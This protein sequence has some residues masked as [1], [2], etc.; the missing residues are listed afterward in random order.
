MTMLRDVAYWRRRLGFLPV[1]LFGDTD[2]CRFVLLNGSKGNFCLDVGHRSEDH[3]QR[4]I[5][6]SADVDH[7]ISVA[8]DVSVYRWDQRSVETY[9]IQE[10]EPNLDKFQGY[11]E[12]RSAPRE[13]SIVS[14]AI[15][16]YRTLRARVESGSDGYTALLAYLALLSTAAARQRSSIEIASEWTDSHVAEQAVL[17]SLRASDSEQL[18]DLLLSESIDGNVPNIELMIRH[19]AGRI[20]QEAHYLAFVDPQLDLFSAGQ[21]TPTG[22]SGAL[23]AFF[24]PTPLVRTV[25]EQAFAALPVAKLREIRIFD[26][27][28]GSGE[29]LR[30]AVRQLEIRRY[31]GNITVIGFDVSQA[32]CAM[33]RFLLAAEQGKWKHRLR[34]EIELRDSLNGQEWPENIQ[35]CLMNPPFVSW[36]GMSSQQK[37][38]VK[39]ALDDLSAM[40]PDM[41]SAFLVLAQRTLSKIGVLGAVLPASL[42]DG[43]SAETQRHYLNERLEFQMLARL[44]SQQIFADALVDPGL[45]V[46]RSRHVANIAGP[47]APTTLVWADHIP[48]SSEKALRVLRKVEPQATIGPIEISPNYSVY[49]VKDVHEAL[50]NWAPRPFD[51]VQLLQ[52]LKNFP[53]VRDFFSVQQGTLTGLNS[54]FLLSTAELESLTKSE[55]KYF[56]PAIV[57]DSIVNGYIKSGTWVFYPYSDGMPPLKIERDVETTLPRYYE[58]WLRPHKK[59]LS[60][61]SGSGKDGWWGLTRP[62]SWQMPIR[63]KIVST[64]FGASGSFAWDQ[65]GE[66]VVVQGYGWIPKKSEMEDVRAYCLLA[67]LTSSVTDRLLSAV[68]NNLSGGQWNLSKRFVE[69]MPLPDI[70]K[71]SIDAQQQLFEYGHAISVGRPIDKRALDAVATSVLNFRPSS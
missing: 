17:S 16:I 27:A 62:R 41:A 38:A 65:S 69:K 2:E 1:P 52:L 24:T 57:N 51:A 53:K 43:D 23:G 45:V 3:R 42:L 35:C 25:V 33:T 37:A 56:R 9:T 5:A 20:F 50:E 46:A 44:G 13:R 67:F 12:S 31:S 26:P 7:Y 58:R 47:N 18:L 39:T 21:A 64:Y 66:F 32:A 60:E 55:R 15:R 11:L 28:C 14:H 22:R 49:V 36:R 8:D 48:E 68:S 6:W 63:P 54:V 59:L 29:F 40:R 19:A 70:E 71:V 61:R 4:Q 10:V 30:E 34:Y